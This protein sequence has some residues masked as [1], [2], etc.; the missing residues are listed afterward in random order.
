MID[1]LLNSPWLFGTLLIILVVAGLIIVG[2]SALSSSGDNSTNDTSTTY[3]QTGI[4]GISGKG[5]K[6]T[7]YNGR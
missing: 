2:L 4:N 7:R 3:H 1:N 5:N 6:Y